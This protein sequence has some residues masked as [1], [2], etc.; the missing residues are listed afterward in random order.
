M[1]V[2]V[3]G[4]EWKEYS[5]EWND[6]EGRKFSFSIM[7]ISKEHA[8]YILEEIKQTARLGDE[9]VGRYHA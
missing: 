7:A 6:V 3:E 9:I 5:I 1:S 4:R 8:S 2:I